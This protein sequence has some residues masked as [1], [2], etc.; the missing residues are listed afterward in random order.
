M[1]VSNSFI[2]HAVY[3]K[4]NG[5]CAYC[6]CEI[7]YKDMQIDHI[8]PKCRNNETRRSSMEC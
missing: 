5:H 4:Y 1:K 8:K 7:D 6:G 3:A 2:R